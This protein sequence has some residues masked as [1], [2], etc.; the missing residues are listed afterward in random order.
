MLRV[1][2]DVLSGAALGLSLL[3]H[4]GFVL[5]FRRATTDSVAKSLGI[6]V[7]DL[8]L[9]IRVLFPVFSAEMQL[10][11][12]LRFIRKIGTHGGGTKLVLDDLTFIRRI[13][14]FF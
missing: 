4:I 6:R 14:P 5:I 13:V 2:E 8:D 10:A 3:E 11:C 7:F 12:R 1:R 9:R